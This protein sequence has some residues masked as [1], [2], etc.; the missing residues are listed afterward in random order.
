MP[1][2]TVPSVVLDTPQDRAAA[3]QAISGAI[4]Y[5]IAAV[6]IDFGPPLDAGGGNFTR[7]ITFTVIDRND[8]QFPP[9][10]FRRKV[11]PALDDRWHIRWATR[12]TK[13]GDPTDYGATYTTGR[14]LGPVGNTRLAETNESGV[15]AISLTK[16][17]GDLWVDAYV[18]GLTRTKGVAFA[19]TPPSG[20]GGGSGPG[21][22]GGSP[23][24]SDKL[25]DPPTTGGGGGFTSFTITQPAQE[26]SYIPQPPFSSGLLIL[27]PA[28][29]PT[30]GDTLVVTDFDGS[31]AQLGWA[32]P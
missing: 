3:F 28:T 1:A 9:I 29:D 18:V 13:Y 23:A 17:A 5:P 12:P 32:A 31:V 10:E 26:T 11:D 27:P 20:G 15:V 2:R 16:A 21:S 7:A 8:R 24:P 6:R 19:V 4:D 22:G 30:V 25:P 14:D